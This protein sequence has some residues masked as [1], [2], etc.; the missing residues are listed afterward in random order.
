MCYDHV[1]IYLK[2]TRRRER[3]GEW[4]G[5]KRKRR[6]KNKIYIS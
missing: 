4:R 2:G 1:S 6:K 3:E 5:T